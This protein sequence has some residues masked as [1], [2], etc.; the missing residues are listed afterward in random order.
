M[1]KFYDAAVSRVWKEIMW[2]SI[3]LLTFADKVKNLYGW[4]VKAL[5]KY[6]LGF[7]FADIT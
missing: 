2:L 6:L 4:L 3:K 7:L 5:L 1:R